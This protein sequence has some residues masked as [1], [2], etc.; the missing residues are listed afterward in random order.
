MSDTTQPSDVEGDDKAGEFDADEYD[1][2]DWIVTPEE[3]KSGNFHTL[4][5]ADDRLSG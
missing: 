2:E 1:G 4:D 5:D 3:L